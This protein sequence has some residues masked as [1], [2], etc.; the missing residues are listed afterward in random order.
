MPCRPGTR[1]DLDLAE[2][3]SFLAGD[4]ATRVIAV[5][6]EGVR[7]PRAFARAAAQALVAHKPIV[8]LKVGRSAAAQRSAASHTGALAGDDAVFDAVCERYGICRVTSLD[9][10]LEITLAFSRGRIPRGTGVA[11]LCHSG[12]IK[13][14]FLDAAESEGLTLANLAVD[15]PLDGGMQMAL[16]A[17]EFGAAVRAYAA[18]PNVDII[19]LQGRLP[20]KE[21]HSPHKLDAYNDL[22][23]AIGKPLV[24]FERMA[25]NVDRETSAAAAMPFL[26][27]IPETVR[28]V[29]ALVR[30]GTRLR[31]RERAAPLVESEPASYAPPPAD[32]AAFVRATLLANGVIFP[33]EV[34]ITDRAQTAAA[35]RGFTYPLVVK[36]ASDSLHKTEAG[37]VRTG[38]RSA[39]EL[40]AAMDAIGG[41]DFLV[42]EFVAGVEI[43]AGVREDAQFGGVAVVGFGG[44]AAEVLQDVALRLLPIDADDVRAMLASLRGTALLGAF[45]GQPARDLDA[46]A[47]AVAGLAQTFLACRAW[48]ADIEINPLIVGAAARVRAQVDLRL[49]FHPHQEVP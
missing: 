20:G 49:S 11:M 38:I 40:D 35:V 6:A 31:A 25:Y 46:L 39:A 33:N 26:H 16:H 19:A 28:A 22:F 27:G 36:L 21:A 44:T 9:D 30:Y 4:D 14:H 7:S 41:R 5:I 12:G 48:L 37:G 13:G 45:R 47:G 23:A 18:E 10:L 29:G 15:N 24:A 3:I 43:V 32:A 17:D 1:L 2:Y 42:Q 34:L 8:M